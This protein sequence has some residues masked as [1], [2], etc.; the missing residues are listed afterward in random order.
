MKFGMRM[1]CKHTYLHITYIKTKITN[2]GTVRYFEY[3]ADGI[4]VVGT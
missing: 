3:T 1:H 4:N 2:M